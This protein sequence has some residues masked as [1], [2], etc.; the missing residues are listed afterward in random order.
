MQQVHAA[1]T[2]S[3]NIQQVRAAGTCSRDMQNG[4]A[5]CIHLIQDPCLSLC[6]V[7]LDLGLEPGFQCGAAQGGKS[8]NSRFFSFVLGAYAFFPLV[9]LRAR[10]SESVEN[11]GAHLCREKEFLFSDLSTI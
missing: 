10:E 3:R 11:A 4:Y 6:R 1:E 8:A 7:D 5:Y 2:S 9:F